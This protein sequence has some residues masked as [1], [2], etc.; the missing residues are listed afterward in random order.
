MKKIATLGFDGYA[1]EESEEGF[2][3]CEC[4]GCKKRWHAISNTPGEAN[5][6]L[7]CGCLIKFM[8]K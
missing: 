8:K 5:I 1:L 6:K 7:I 2:W 3:Y 4:D